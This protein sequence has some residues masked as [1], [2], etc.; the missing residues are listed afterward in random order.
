MLSEEENENSIIKNG[1]HIPLLFIFHSV[2]QIVK[3]YTLMH[4]FLENPIFYFQEVMF[5]CTVT[6]VDRLG[7]LK[8]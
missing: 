6:R 3:K 4:G 1:I 7:I 8:L 2:E 5:C